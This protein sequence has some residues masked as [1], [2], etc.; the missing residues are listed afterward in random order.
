M[1]KL[2][3]FLLAL[4][5]LIVF[6]Q[7]IS[8]RIIYKETFKMDFEGREMPPHM[9][10]MMKNMPQEQ[11]VKKQLIFDQ[12]HS[13]FKTWEDPNEP[14][15]AEVE[16]P[17]GWMRMMMMRPEEET[18]VNQDENRIAQKKD[19][20]GKTFLVKDTLPKVSWKIT[21]E[22]KQVLDYNCMKATT[23]IDSNE[24]EA[25]FCPT[26]PVS[27]GPEGVGQL[28]GIIL[29]ASLRKG[30]MSIVAQKVELNPENLEEITEPNKGKEVTS[31]EFKTIVAEKRKEMR[32][33][34]QNG[35]GWGGHR[36]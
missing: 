7:D 17:G 26:L 24:V 33:M 32:E 28:P 23:V 14:V 3:P 9:Q 6:A 30:R 34:R 25:W 5:P 15:A 19:A 31:A 22:M 11:S 13:L 8:G 2:I 12:H 27:V 20:F 29:E 4:L 16:G 21:G 35:G 10:E 1:K 18:Y 36:H